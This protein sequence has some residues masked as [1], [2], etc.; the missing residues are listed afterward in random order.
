MNKFLIIALLSTNVL[1][2]VILKDG[3][4]PSGYYQSGV[5]CIGVN[6]APAIKK[7]GVC[8]SG[9]HQSGSYCLG[10]STNVGDVIEKM[11][12]CPSGYYQSGAYCKEN[13]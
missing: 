5:Y 9:Y 11:G 7:N 2:G 4:C 1:A 6:S 8:P 3:V 12:T 13:R 10:N